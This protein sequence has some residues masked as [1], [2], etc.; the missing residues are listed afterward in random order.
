MARVSIYTARHLCTAPRPQKEADALTAAG[1]AVAV[2]GIAFDREMARRDAEITQ[3]KAWRWEPVMDHTTGGSGP[4]WFGARIRH[5][6]AKMIYR[7]TGR[8]TSD[9]WGYNNREL[10]QHALE[11]ATDLTIVHAEG[12]LWFGRELMLRGRRVGVD[13]ED[14]F[15]QDLTPDQRRGRP[16]AELEQ[17]EQ[18]YCRKTK[19]CLTTSRALAQAMA[20]RGGGPAPAVIYNSFLDEPQLPPPRPVNGPVKLHWF[21][22]V[23]GPHRGLEELFD[24]LRLIQGEW[25]LSLRGRVEPAYRDHLL[26]RLDETK[27]SRV[28]FLPLVPS[29]DLARALM[30]F[31]VGLSL[32]RSEIP[33]RNL[34]ITNKFFHYLQ[35]GL[36]IVASDTAGNREG[37]GNAPSAGC[38][39]PPGRL[40]EALARVVE[41]PDQT[42]RAKQAAREQFRGRFAHDHQA[43]R[44]AELVDEVLSTR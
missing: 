41:H 4:G 29:A 31:D 2:H 8:I 25:T 19:Y 44:Y 28:S 34:T 24:T 40:H 30:D 37:L 11:H 13:F 39:F 14:W 10:R 17:L 20:S 15:S 32:E 16:V 21:S 18:H 12:G 1:H 36:A 22:L 3:G 5:R 6:I 26:A 23:V 43:G 42:Y 7:A 38:I 9:V 33:S 35:S 27:R